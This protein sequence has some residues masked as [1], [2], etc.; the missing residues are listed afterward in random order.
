MEQLLGFYVIPE[1]G[2]FGFLCAYRTNGNIYLCVIR[3]RPSYCLARF[4]SWNTGRYKFD[5]SERQ[6]FAHM[7]FFNDKIHF[8]KLKIDRY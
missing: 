6:F 5:T 8:N 4:F 2:N 7:V 1:T 3:A